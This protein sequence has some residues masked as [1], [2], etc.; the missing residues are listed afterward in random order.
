M[1]SRLWPPACAPGWPPACAP[2]V[3]PTCSPE[4]PPCPPLVLPWCC[5]LWPPECAP[6]CPRLCSRLWPPRVLQRAPHQ[7]CS[8]LW[9]RACAPEWPPFAVGCDFTPVS[10]FPRAEEWNCPSLR[11]ASQVGENARAPGPPAKLALHTR[12]I[13]RAEGPELVGAVGHNDR[14]FDGGKALVLRAPP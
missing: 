5:S 1:C 4:W 12:A 6:E 13:N 10:Y 9:P 2:V 14:P 11:T 3:A 8:R 7:L